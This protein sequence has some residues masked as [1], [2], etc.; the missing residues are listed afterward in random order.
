MM[1]TMKDGKSRE[2]LAYSILVDILKRLFSF[3][4]FKASSIFH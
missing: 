3:S 2:N 4:I 1:C